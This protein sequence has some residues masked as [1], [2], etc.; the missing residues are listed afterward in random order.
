[1]MKHLLQLLSFFSAALLCAEPLLFQES[2]STPESVR[3]YY[4]WVVKTGYIRE[5]DG[6]GAL[7]LFLA[8]HK[9]IGTISISLKPQEIAGKRLRISAEVKGERLLR[10]KSASTEESS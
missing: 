7:K 5:K 2:F 10:Q 6:S 3:K 9:P 8:E 4:P 1:M